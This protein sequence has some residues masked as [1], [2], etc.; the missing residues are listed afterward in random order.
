M[1]NLLLVLGIVSVLGLL[2][3]RYPHTMINPGE[4][5]QGHQDLKENCF[6]C[7]SPFNGIPNEKCIACHKISEIGMVA[8]NIQDSVGQH[9]PI[10]FHQEL[11]NQTC[12]SCH[13][14]HK[15]IEPSTALM[16][17]NHE[18]L[19]ATVINNCTSCHQKPDNKLHAQLTTNCKSCHNTND[20]NS[21]TAFNHDMIQGNEKNNCAGCHQIP[22]DGLHGSIKDN[23]IKCHSTS[24]WVPASF[25]HSDYFVL[26]E[27]HNAKCS[28][29]H[30]KQDFSNYTCYGCHEH[31]ESNIRSEHNEEGIY[32]F[33]NCIACHRSGNEDDINNG[34]DYQGQDGKQRSN[35]NKSDDDDD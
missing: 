2:I 3:V 21:V 26:N 11:A 18:M 27:N 9:K 12:I 24:K 7:H 22:K 17:F 30:L 4:L 19:S 32:N 14:D 6:S 25:E 20:W 34:G 31:S 13:S 8:S 16:N 15:G 23:C 29:C 35:N 5:L 1:K 10:A 33:A 28:V